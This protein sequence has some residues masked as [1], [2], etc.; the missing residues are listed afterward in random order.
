MAKV[1]A[2]LTRKQLIIAQGALIGEA[3]RKRAAAR[4]GPFASE[5]A[6]KAA[7]KA[8]K[9][10]YGAALAIVEATSKGKKAKA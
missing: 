8:A 2:K 9:R 1:A 4:M 3:L 10:A 6:R 5:K 7:K